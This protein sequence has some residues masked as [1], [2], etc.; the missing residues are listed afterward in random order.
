MKPLRFFLLLLALALTACASPAGQ[1]LRLPLRFLPAQPSPAATLA[2]GQPSPT[3]TL[4][5]TWTPQPSVTP[6]PTR[7]SP[8]PVQ[9]GTPLPDLG[10]PEMGLGNVDLLKP[11]FSASEN[12][13]LAFT[14]SYDGSQ[15]LVAALDGLHAFN[16]SGE[17][18]A[19]WP[20]IRLFDQPCP[21]CLS[22]NADGSL[23]AVIMRQAGEW[24]VRL[25]ALGGGQAELRKSWPLQAAFSLL[26][27]PGVIAL[28]PD[29]RLLALGPQ[30]GPLQVIDWETDAAVFTYR[31]QAQ[32]AQFS[33]DG[34]LFYLQR[35]REMLAW[36]TAQWGDF[37]SLLLP[38]EDT[39][40]AFSPNGR[41]MAVALSSLLRVYSTERFLQAH[42]I[43]IDPSYV[44][45]RRW[46][47]AFEDDETLRGLGWR[48]AQAGEFPLSQLR[49]NVVSGETLSAQEAASQA[50]PSL[51]SF[52]QIA[53]E[54]L[55][56]P[57]GLA[58][59]YASLRF[60]G[61]DVVLLNA[62]HS[63]CWLR[64]STGET[65]CQAD[66]QAF[67]HAGD[68]LV[69]REQRGDK[70]NQVFQPNGELLYD[71]DPRPLRW[72]ARDGSLALADVEGAT[73]DLYTPGISQ[74][75]QSFP[76][77]LSGAA[78]N[79]SRLFTLTR[80][81]TGA[82]YVTI[83]D[84]ASHEVIF[85]IKEGF[86]HAPLAASADGRAFFFKKIFGGSTSVLKQIDAAGKHITDLG[87][88]DFP[89]EP[90]SLAVASNGTLAAGLEDGSVVV[91]SA[92]GLQ[93]RLLQ[94][95]YA[96]VQAL[97]FSPDGRYLAA[98]SRTGLQLLA[99]L[100]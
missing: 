98:A 48:P 67:L 95:F 1:P 20:Q 8:Y 93:H 10:F 6:R 83:V 82:A 57:L 35:G 71:L 44:K 26:T 76:G 77:T 16:R 90:L 69:Y 75:V 34:S 63:A 92:D 25:Y 60:P 99:V 51:L 39:P 59:T 12:R 89:A 78:E 100:R 18:I 55:T 64:F 4:R 36:Q 46:L 33:A 52:H 43:F 14:L 54:P 68:V 47:I 74:L 61:L 45:N 3:V 87:K 5:P 32:R 49:W 88:I 24:Q 97:A 84:K 96:P 11:V 91:F 30:D 50:E 7:P 41:W 80:E 62:P 53:F 31:G 66:E 13:A 79:G 9:P 19:F 70:R 73:T 23:A 72:F 28:S 65:N 21:A 17:Q 37:A 40:Y 42:E 2:P 15:A 29:G 58:E 38:A 94:V 86:L 27:P 81:K 85:Q 56:A 22:V